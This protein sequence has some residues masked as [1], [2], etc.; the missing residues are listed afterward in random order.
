MNFPGNVF[1]WAILTFVLIGCASPENV[2]SEPAPTL[3]ATAIPPIVESTDKLPTKTISIPTVPTTNSPSPTSTS[4]PTPTLTPTPVLTPT[5]E[6]CKEDG[7]MAFGEFFSPIAGRNHAYRIYLPPCYAD[8]GKVYP[9]LYV[10]HGSASTESYWDD[11]GLDETA[12]ELIHSGDVAPFVIVMPEGGWI[13]QNSSG[14]PNSFEGLV[15]NDLIPF[16]ERE[17]CVWPLGDG[18]AL[19]G[20]SRGGYWSLEIAFRNPSSFQSVGAHS[21]ALLDTFAGPDLNPQYT[22]ITNDLGD[23]RVYMDTGESDWYINQFQQL[24]NDMEFAGKPHTWIL[25]EGSHEDAYWATHQVEYLE[26]YAE[27]WE[28]DRETY[29]DC[30]LR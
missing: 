25:N 2:E 18:R 8:D 10:L 20:V 7:Q 4:T 15:L 17:Y 19:G 13:S 5:P 21:A 27:P 14:G 24:H 3:A 26:W 9:A 22:G 29:P 23:L 12:E 6:S 28:K 1:S 30:L 11:L 16:I